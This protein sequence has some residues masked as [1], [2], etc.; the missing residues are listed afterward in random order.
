MPAPCSGS[1]R[2]P[3]SPDRPGPSTAA[4]SLIGDLAGDEAAGV[5]TDLLAER[6]ELAQDV[7]RLATARL[8]AVAPAEVEQRV[9]D[10]FDRL[11][12]T[13][14]AD[15]VGRHGGGYV[16]ETEAAATLMAERLEPYCR[17][18]VRLA[19]AGCPTPPS[20]SGSR[21]SPA[22]T[23][24]ATRRSPGRCW[25]GSRPRTRRGSWR[26]AWSSHSTTRASRRR[27]KPLTRGSP[28]GRGS[29]DLRGRRPR[30]RR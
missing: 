24:S 15:R 20:R 6:P 27:R 25:N 30:S 29:P 8:R 22:C 7:S 18:V 5:L 16:D 14:I 2:S 28:T 4:R 10:D 9:V 23:G 11:H 19:G 13:A 26:P 1:R 17:E 12:F 21:R 3:A